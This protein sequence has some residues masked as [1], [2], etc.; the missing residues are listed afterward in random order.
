MIKQSR[1]PL[2]SKTL[3]EKW[4][5]IQWLSKL[6][7]KTSFW[8]IKFWALKVGSEVKVLPEVRTHAVRH[9]PW[10]WKHG[11]ICRKTPP[12]IVQITLNRR[13]ECLPGPTE[14]KY[15]LCSVHFVLKFKL[16]SVSKCRSVTV[17]CSETSG[18]CSL[19]NG[20]LA[21]NIPMMWHEKQS[22]IYKYVHF[23]VVLCGLRILDYSDG[24][25]RV[26]S[27]WRT[28]AAADVRFTYQGN[29][30]KFRFWHKSCM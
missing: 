24:M 10:W 12:F 3:L 22:E 21:F 19:Q 16:S 13:S 23:N 2:R 4:Q 20:I 9:R 15:T 17:K 8:T 6:F 7:P 14:S 26:A 18:C 1:D 5:M 25:C 30:E 11:T 29:A 27:F 28:R